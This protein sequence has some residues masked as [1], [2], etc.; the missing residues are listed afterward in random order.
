VKPLAE[1][2]KYFDPKKDYAQVRFKP[3]AYLQMSELNELQEMQDYHRKQLG[4]GV[5][6]DGTMIQGMEFV[7]DEEENE[8][9]VEDGIVYV[10][11]KVRPFKKQTIPFTGEG[12]E[13]IGVKVERTLVTLDEDPDLLRHDFDPQPDATDISDRVHERVYITNNDE[14]A[15]TIF[16]FDEGRLYIS[17]S[18]P[19]FSLINQRMAE[20][21]YDQS[22]SFRVN[23]FEMWTE[24]SDEEGMLNVVID[25]G[26][27]YIQG[28]LVDKPN[29]T[30]VPIPKSQEIRDVNRE[31]HTYDDGTRR[32]RITS[33]FVSEVKLVVGR[34]ASPQ[35]GVQMSKGSADG[36][37][38]L[39]SEYTSIDRE[40]TTLWTSSPNVTYTYG[41]DY[42]IIEE[43]GISY[44]D[45]DQGL[46]S[47]EPATGSTYHITFEYDRQMVKDTDYHIVTD[48][49]EG[50]V[51]RWSTYI[52]FNGMSGVKPVDQGLLS[53][54]YDYYLHRKD[55]IV[56]DS[57]G[58]FTVQEGQP[59]TERNV[60]EPDQEDPLSLKMGTVL[61][62]PNSHQGLA[63]SNAVTRMRMEDIQ[64][65]RRR[66][67]QV[68]YNQSIMQLELEATISEDPLD[69]RGVFADGFVDFSRVDMNLTDVAYSFEDAS[70]T[71][72][73][74]SPSHLKR[75]PDVIFPTQAHIWGRLVT[76]P[77]TENREIWQPLVSEAW[78]VN[79]YMLFNRQGV[80]SLNPSSD[81]WIEED[82]VIIEEEEVKE[83]N[84]SRWWV[85]SDQE[86]GLRNRDQ[87]ASGRLADI[88]FDEGD[89]V[90]LRGGIGEQTHGTITE[91]SQTTTEK[92]ID[93]MRRIE[94]EFNVRNLTPH[95]NNLALSFDGR[96]VDI[97]PTGNTVQGSNSGTVRS[98]GQGECSG[99]FTIPRHVRTGTREVL[100]ENQDNLATTTFT[101]H[102]IKR[103]VEETVLRTRV[104]ATFVDPL[105]Q[106]FGFSNDR[107]VSSVGL[108]FGS[109]SQSGENLTVQIR[110]MSEGGMP[111]RTV[112]A[113][114]MLTPAE[115]N[116]SE[117]A[118]AET[119][120][121]FD[122]PLMAK[123]GQSYCIVCLTDS[124]NYTMW[125]GTLGEPLLN[126]PSQFIE[127]QPYANGVLFS[128]SNAVT[129][130]P[131]QRSNLKF[132]VYTATFQE[133]A[134][135]QFDVM[136]DI[137]ADKIMVMANH[138]TPANTGCKWEVRIVR[139]EDVENV[140]ID[141]V[142]WRPLRNYQEQDTQMVVG[143]AQLRAH[144]KSNR[145]ISP[146][147]VLDD[148]LFV[149][150]ITRTEG[151]YVS[152]NV[153]M[154][155]APYNY[156]KLAY[157]RFTPA[158]STVTPFY[159]LDGG[160]TWNE[161]EST[162]TTSVQSG[163]FSRVTFNEQVST[164][165]N[166]TQFK[167]K[168]EL[169]GENRFSRP[170]VRRLTALMR[171]EFV[172]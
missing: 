147:L 158:G 31:T 21:L 53:I 153:D 118:S 167:V 110:G 40:S 33:N 157:D 151:D 55:L 41:D 113:E 12:K 25:S 85:W 99:K 156:I 152:R 90:D 166:N 49:H 149:N 104:T 80:M 38:Q 96:Q 84:I 111:N 75:K 137:D 100:L 18:R 159:S 6:Q 133:M 125:V 29:S 16:E 17:P 72:Q 62:Y 170:R 105:A 13:N 128:S 54:D 102:G 106:A 126:N 43:A 172:D 120:V 20:Q 22:G 87:N 52:D 32:N 116:V 69:L 123:A 60:A 2:E 61:V 24:E 144:F 14:D 37:D 83:L 146:M 42:R 8:I 121:S 19:E 45:W 78:N 79:P 11:G 108:Y 138:L 46:N 142:P 169:R 63:N 34:T 66:L 51:P 26:R 64:R 168:L 44:V 119:K 163:T 28:R 94:V 23:G 135:I 165:A 50:T 68:E 155:E 57:K 27:A 86:A 82:R 131:H 109:K 67:E 5:F 162:P 56:L 4:N 127:S 161:F 9:T 73:V 81:S 15:P 58:D 154:S 91:T 48:Y 101:A 122:D 3:D 93:F 114:R 124:A 140:N 148:L 141:N 107:V 150:F 88:D 132:A 35:S 160:Q 97:T 74:A 171:D 164:T 130:T 103:R 65:M 145:F 95:T 76:A 36:R 71:L 115:V 70:I 129:W 59:E 136:D 89:F 98:N 1:F 117:D 30:T 134:T 143:K 47:T 10:A 39:P 112:Y 7:I 139:E 77:F 92:A